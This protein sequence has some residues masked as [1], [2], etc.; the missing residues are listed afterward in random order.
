MSNLRT[1]RVYPWKGGL[2]TSAPQSLLPVDSCIQATNV[3]YITSGLKIKRLGT[4]R[5]NGTQS[6]GAG[7]RTFTAIADFWRHGAALSPTQDF[8][9][10]V[11]TRTYKDDGD[12]TWDEINAAWGTDASLNTNITVAQGFA[13]FSNGVD[14]PRTWD[15]TTEAAL[16]GTPPTFAY[17]TYHLRRLFVAGIAATPSQ[18]TFS[19]A[20]AIATWSGVD[21]GNLIFDEDDGDRVI[22]LS[23]PFHGRLFVFKGPTHGSIHELSGLSPSTFNRT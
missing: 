12:G 6:G 13:V 20:G 10:A 15:Q 1:F 3:E 23:K 21:S 2:L 18:V 14:A 8:V 17:A 7:A 16:G 9:A 5:Y 11:G 4:T 19:A 22:G